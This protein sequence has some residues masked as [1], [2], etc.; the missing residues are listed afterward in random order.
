[1][2]YA[3]LFATCWSLTGVLCAQEPQ[4]QDK[5]VPATVLRNEAA[6]ESKGAPSIGTPNVEKEPFE[7]SLD[8]EMLKDP[9]VAARLST[10]YPV[11]GEEWKEYALG[12]LEMEMQE[13]IDDLSNGKPKPPAHVTQPRILSRLDF[14]IAELEK[15]CNGGAGSSNAG[16]R[17]AEKSGIKKGKM[18]DGQMRAANKEGDRWANLSPKEREK[19]L[20]SQNDG[21]PVGYEDVLADYFRKLSK[22][23]QP[24]SN[25]KM[26]PDQ[27]QE[28]ANKPAKE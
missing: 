18:L 23:D 17:P 2:K 7:G 13:V 4:T 11:E 27:S 12:V 10:E 22:S 16:N 9:D 15:K 8:P 24:A 5:T 14:M 25:I 28:P 6:T 1:M 19:I 21:F 26:T 3:Y 20:Q